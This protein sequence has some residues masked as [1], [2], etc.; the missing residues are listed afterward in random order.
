M[1]TETLKIQPSSDTKVQK[2]NGFI[3]DE[4][5]IKTASG[6]EINITG[7]WQFIELYEDLFSTNLSGRILINDAHNWIKSGPIVGQE[8]IIITFKTA[9]KQTAISNS[10]RLYKISQRALMK[11]GKVQVYVLDFVS[12]EC[13]SNI[14]A[15]CNYS[16]VDKTVDEMVST[17]FDTHFPDS[18]LEIQ[19]RAKNKHTFILPNRSPFKCINWLGRRAISSTN[20]DDCS[21]IFYRDMDSFK[22][23]TLVNLV[24]RP[25]AHQGVYDYKL[26]NVRETPNTFRN[27]KENFNNPDTLRFTKNSD[28]LKETQD[29]M[30]SSSLYLYDILTGVYVAKTHDYFEHFHSTFPSEKQNPILAETKDEGAHTNTSSLVHYYP[31]SSGNIGTTTLEEITNSPFE[32]NNDKYEDWVLQRESLEQQFQTNKIEIDIQGNSD[33]RVGDVVE[34][35]LNSPEPIKMGSTESH[36]EPYVSGKYLVTALKHSISKQDYKMTLELSRNYLP[37]L[38]PTESHGAMNSRPM[39]SEV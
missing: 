18:L 6:D 39:K 9:G 13:F 2:Q 7:Q 12:N 19:T 8:Q 22:F 3:I 34:F 24:S 15:K 21:F 38:L 17:I 1:S 30:Y 32:K 4:I 14:S 33:R 37:E 27:A 28:K 11:N 25:T 36:I 29:G 10:F 23:D 5:I 35:N 26:M 20:P 16:L 31:K